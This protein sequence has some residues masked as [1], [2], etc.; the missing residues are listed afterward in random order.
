MERI[1]RTWKKLT[2][3]FLILVLLAPICIAPASAEYWQSWETGG[4]TYNKDTGESAYPAYIAEKSAV[5]TDQSKYL[6]ELTLAV[7]GNPVLYPLDV[8]FVLDRS[9]S[10]DMDYIQNGTHS[11]SCPCLNQ[12]HF[13]LKPIGKTDQPD[14]AQSTDDII[15]DPVTGYVVVYNAQFDS[16]INLNPTPEHIYY[17]FAGVSTSKQDGTYSSTY[18]M[19]PYHFKMVNGEY[20]RIS[21][22]DTAD[23][24][25]VTISREGTSN[26]NTDTDNSKYNN[27]TY[28]E[29]DNGGVWDHADS[30]K[31]C[32][33]RWTEAKNS[34]KSFTQT[35]LAQNANKGAGD[36]KNTV[37]VVPFSRRDQTMDDFLNTP[38]M[39]YQKQWLNSWLAENNYTLPR[40]SGGVYDSIVGWTTDANG[41]SSSLDRLFTTSQTDYVYGLSQAY[42]MLSV[43]EYQ[44][45]KPAVVIFLS[46]GRPYP[47]DS[48]TT[49]YNFTDNPRVTSLSTFGSTDTWIKLLS[50]AIKSDE[51]PYVGN[52]YVTVNGNEVLRYAVERF[53][54]GIEGAGHSAVRGGHMHDILKKNLYLPNG[55]TGKLADIAGAIGQNARILTIAY[56][57]NNQTY[58]DRLLGMA[59]NAYS[60]IEIPPSAEGSSADYIYSRL[61]KDMSIYPGGRDSVLRD[62]VSDYF[63]V[64]PSYVP[65]SETVIIGGVEKPVIEIETEKDSEGNIVRQTIVWNIGDIY[66]YTK[67]DQPTIKIPLILKE[68]YRDVTSITYYPTNKD[69]P[70]PGTDKP[71]P[72][73]DGPDTGGK[74]Y[75]VDPE[76]DERY[77]TIGTPKLPIGEGG[78]TEPK[79]VTVTLPGV[80]KRVTG[81]NAPSNT[82]FTFILRAQDG[83]PMPEGTAGSTKAV[84]I[85][86][87][88]S[89]A[90]G[91]VS[92]TSEGTYSYTISEVKASVEGYTCDSAVY[93]LVVTV[94][95]KDNE[96]IASSVLTRNSESSPQSAAVF[97]N[98]YE[99]EP[100]PE[101]ENGDLT[102]YLNKVLTDENGNR[103]GDGK[104][105]AAQVLDSAGNVVAEVKLPANGAAVAIT[106]LKTGEVYTVHEMTGEYFTVRGYDVE[107]SGFVDKEYV[108]FRS[109]ATS[110]SALGIVR[111]TVQNS[112]KADEVENIPDPE[113][114]TF[115]QPP[116][117]EEEEIVDI[118]PEEVPLDPGETI[119]GGPATSDSAPPIWLLIFALLGSGISIVLL[120]RK[121]YLEA[122]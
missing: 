23:V 57:L 46:D 48:G 39:K 119:P 6:A 67:A 75:F 45:K 106:G 62:V 20:A 83:A 11:S 50:D 49:N 10:M 59:S 21:E 97:T 13:Y 78:T 93:N 25:K 30:G 108:I 73:P 5:W 47:A 80:Q 7:N 58:K 113:T 70:D 3:F 84:T 81:D 82:G 96:L 51:T 28:T 52:Y 1:R 4:L 74:L 16:W 115:P 53:W 42:N 24:R 56:M 104:L 122:K 54:T 33:D 55:D 77:D 19:A 102:L 85:S 37:A 2:A 118:T 36:L 29:S 120:L 116:K 114:P 8:I 31:G 66:K 103:I 101:P 12:E 95:K 87:N 111:I 44:D 38:E 107:N 99:G 109:A 88:G 61:T 94:T 92:Y 17:E 27:Y 100:E 60:Y 15:V 79:P 117:I 9:G 64:D 86:G 69:N 76:G 34:I 98:T 72:G 110:E 90:F 32:Y 91:S 41:V 22:W 105:F 14:G 35:L 71:G 65:P 63:I 121:N 40:N 18:D 68:E 43:R 26:G 89:A 112:C